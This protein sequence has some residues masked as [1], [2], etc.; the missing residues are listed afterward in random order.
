MDVQEVVLVSGCR[1][2]IGKFMG[3]L[4]DV[5]ARTLAVTAG[6]AAI[7]RAGIKADMVD[8]IV[9]G[10]CFQ[11]M[12]GSLPARQ[13]A[14]EI[15]LP[16]RSG[17]CVVN[18]NCTSG[19]RALEIAA[20]NLMLGK[21]EIALVVGV[22]SMTN[23]PYLLPKARM[24]Y[25]MNQGTIEDSMIH[26]GL[27]DR[28]VPGHMGVTAENV[29]AM[30]GI[31]REQCDQHAILSHQRAT[32]AIKEGRFKREIIPSSPEIEEGHRQFRTGRASNNGREHGSHVG[33]QAGF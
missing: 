23:A 32:R 27:Y 20:H 8:D 22:E 17:A 18:Q 10:E 30:F 3:G 7:E 6:K 33:A 31:T 26:D 9:M 16:F 1:T 11:G 28:M 25:R 21:T 4:K 5:E 12:Q 29:A 15:G 19:M 14:M 13:V 2:A 24:G